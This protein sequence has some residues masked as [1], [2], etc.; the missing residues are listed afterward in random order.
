MLDVSRLAAGIRIDM[1]YA[2]SEN[3][4]GRPIDGYAAPR[5]LLKVE[6]AAALARVQ[7]E[8]DKQ[9]MRLRVFDCYRPVRAV[10]EFVAWAGEASDPVA[11]ERHYPNLDKSA[12][13]GD[14]I[15]PVSGHSKGY[16]VDLGLERCLAEPQGCTA[17]DMGTPFD[18]FDP[19]ANTDSAEITPVQR[20]N[21]Q[22]LLDAMQAEGFN[23]YPMEWWH[24]THASGA[25]AEILYDFVI[26]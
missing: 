18:F 10:Q 13:L 11:K 19:R 25:G 22:L 20:A 12:L 24:F 1:R 6:A 2:G 8:L 17:L 3:F 4:V 7:R 23:N 5:C 26:R 16:T 9:S 15:A 21:R 14:Y